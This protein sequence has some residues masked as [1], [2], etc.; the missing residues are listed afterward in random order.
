MA[1]DDTS[2]EHPTPITK[3]GVITIIPASALERHLG[4]RVRSA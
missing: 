3:Y 1:I 2:G 4:V